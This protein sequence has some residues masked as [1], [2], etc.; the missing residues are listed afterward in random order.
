MAF[1]INQTGIDNFT[2]ANA[3]LQVNGV[4]AVVGTTVNQGDELTAVAN[5][6]FAF[7]PNSV[8]LSTQNQL[9]EMITEYFTV[10][11]PPTTATLIAGDYF[12]ANFTVATEQATPEVVG[13]NNV[14]LIDNDIL[15]QVNEQRFITDNTEIVDYGE[16]ILSVI[17][18]P[19]S[20]DPEIIL[21]S[22][23]I[24]LGNETLTATAQEI[25]ADTIPINMGEISVPET[26][27]NSLDFQNTVC[28][29]HLPYTTTVAVES[30]YVIGETVGIEYLLDV[31]TG[32]VTIN[33][34]ST[35]V[36]GEVFFTKKSS[37][38]VNIPYSARVGY[39]NNVQNMSIDVGGNN[40][41]TVAYMEVTRN[42]APLSSGF[43]SV[44]IVDESTIGN[45]SGYIEVD[46]VNLSFAAIGNEKE[47]I[48]AML[49]N[50]VIIQ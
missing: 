11:D 14:Y 31:Y 21:E 27:G 26:Y 38:G 3:K 9:G 32:N 47:E 5:S 30:Y 18:I 39:T 23:P 35:K 48:K 36:N 33:L 46:N 6:G 19:T 28:Q 49:S 15:T 2:N 13:S 29:L 42:D 43:F 7:Y 44:P 50:G 12:F 17:K 37:L 24:Q 8:S 34:T 25:S 1:S 22:V 45:Q 10:N 20:I 41:L 40:H 4:D 16:Y